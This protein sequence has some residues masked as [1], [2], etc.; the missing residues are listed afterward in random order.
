MKPIIRVQAIG[1]TSQMPTEY[2]RMYQ[3]VKHRV[4]S[5]HQHCSMGAIQ[6]PD[7]A[8]MLK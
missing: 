6:Y 4:Q 5:T 7:A 8:K 2:F 3:G 1:A